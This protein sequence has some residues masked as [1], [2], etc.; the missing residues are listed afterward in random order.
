MAEAFLAIFSDTV[1]RGQ[2]FCKELSCQ[3]EYVVDR[4]VGRE[5]RSRWIAR[6][7]R[8]NN[9]NNNNNNS[10]NKNNRKKKKKKEVENCAL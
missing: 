4:V 9:N 2:G 3:K 8:G 6:K 1:G 10:D 7:S 5:E